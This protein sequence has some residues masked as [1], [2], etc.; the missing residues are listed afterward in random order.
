MLH[1]SHISNE[2]ISSEIPLYEGVFSEGERIKA[3]IIAKDAERERF[4]AST[5][6]LEKRHGDMLHNRDAV[7][8][9]AEEMDRLFREEM[10]TARERMAEQGQD[11]KV[12]ER[13]RGQS[14]DGRHSG[15]VTSFNE[16]KGWGHI[17]SPEIKELYGK[18]VFLHR[19]N[20]EED[21]EV[22]V[23]APVS[24]TIGTRDGK[25]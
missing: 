19:D 13:A 9:T 23:G 24:F 4:T 12:R 11:E 16:L 6:K 2:P 22:I 5:K 1:R 7:Y 21:C 14:G 25:P 17:S 10:A 3:V 18:D 20:L 15:V 8:E